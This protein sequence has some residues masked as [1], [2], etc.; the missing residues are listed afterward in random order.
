MWVNTELGWD[1]DW[2]VFTLYSLHN[3]PSVI[4]SHYARKFPKY[5]LFPHHNRR[6]FLQ[7]NIFFQ[8]PESCW[9]WESVVWDY[10]TSGLVVTRSNW[11]SFSPSSQW[12]WPWTLSQQR[13][14]IPWENMRK[15][16]MRS[17]SSMSSIS[18]PLWN[19]ILPLCK[20]IKL[21]L[22]EGS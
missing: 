21:G 15:R 13:G 1:C 3:T 12:D 16:I 6:C 14:L 4:S 18:S 8:W 7:R 17:G 10:Q 19:L 9:W 20:M 5:L 2:L 22:Y 11:K